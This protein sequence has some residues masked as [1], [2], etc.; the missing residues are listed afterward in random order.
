MT[1]WFTKIFKGKSSKRT[2]E[3]KESF[4]SVHQA[5]GFRDSLE[6][7][8]EKSD[9]IKMIDQDQVVKRSPVWDEREHRLSNASTIGPE[10]SLQP[11]AAEKNTGSKKARPSRN[12]AK[13]LQEN[14]KSML[15]DMKEIESGLRQISAK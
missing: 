15:Q 5:F 10:V 9:D 6:V 3:D 1:N 13:E 8:H 12:I 4:I 14:F 7:L 11:I 2:E